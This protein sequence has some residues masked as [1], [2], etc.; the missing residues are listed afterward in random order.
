LEVEHKAAYRVAEVP[1]QEDI[2]EIGA[3]RMV[4]LRVAAALA[5][6]PPVEVYSSPVAAGAESAVYSSPVVAVAVEA[7]SVVCS[8]P[9]VAAGVES[10]VCSLPVTVVWEAVHHSR[11]QGEAEVACPHW[12][13]AGK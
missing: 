5:R 9:A 6:I 3:V 4:R 8:L 13:S 7:E 10:A 2:L 12:L 1:V 11:V